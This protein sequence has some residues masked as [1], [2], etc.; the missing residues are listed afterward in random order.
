MICK[1]SLTMQEDN[2]MFEKI[3][4]DLEHII[5]N[6]IN[7]RLKTFS[8]VPVTENKNKSPILYERQNGSEHHLGLESWCVKHIYKYASTEL[9]RV[10]RLLKKNRLSVFQMETLN[11]YL[12]GALLIN[13][14]V[15]TFWNMKKELIEQ[16]ILQTGKELLFTKLVLSHKSKSNDTFNHRRWLLKRMLSNTKPECYIDMLPEEFAV[17]EFAAE[18]AENNYHAWTHRIWCLENFLFSKTID[19]Q[20]KS[21]VIFEQLQFSL[22][23]INNHISQHSGYHYRQYLINCI[24]NIPTM[25]NSISNTSFMFVKNLLGLSIED[26]SN[27]RSFINKLLG[28]SKDYASESNNYSNYVCILLYELFHTLKTL[29]CFYPKHETIWYHRKFIV[30]HLLQWMYDCY[31]IEWQP[32]IN[33]SNV[34]EYNVNVVDN[35]TYKNVKFA[36]SG[37]KFAKLF[38]FETDRLDSSLLYQIIVQSEFDIVKTSLSSACLHTQKLAERYERWLK[39]IACLRGS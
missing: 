17:T 7:S 8:V 35:C 28:E 1:K 4:G 25:N 13:P 39:N 32:K 26:M 10:R 23:W 16:D 2:S 22:G 14:E 19:Y 9:F 38:K 11:K 33:L 31:G 24:K 37:E 18:K 5:E 21:N 34:C 12:V 27:E 20:S 30:Y 29:F 15:T 6:D 36:E 3:L